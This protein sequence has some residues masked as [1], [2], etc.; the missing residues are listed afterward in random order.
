MQ[1]AKQG[2]RAVRQTITWTVLAFVVGG[3]IDTEWQSLIRLRFFGYDYAIF[4]YAFHHI[5]Q[6]AG[7]VNLYNGMLQQVYLH[8]LNYP[9]IVY[10]Q[11]V[12]PPQFALVWSVL[13]LLPF[14]V[15]LVLWLTVEV[16]CYGTSVVLLARM[17]WPNIR[18]QPAIGLGLTTAILT[19]FILDTGVANV[20]CVLL[21]AVVATFAT[22]HRRPKSWAAGIPLGFAIAFKVTPLAIVVYLLLR[23]QWRT[24][25]S[26]VMTAL[27]LSV[28]TALVVG[29]GPLVYYL[30]H[31]V[32]F[33]QTSM[34]NGPAP[35]NQSL[36]GVLQLYGLHHALPA[37]PATQRLIFLG[38][39]LMV[40]LIIGWTTLR[41]KPNLLMDMGLAS[42]TPLLF[43]PLVEQMHM[44]LALPAV[45]VLMKT[46]A[47][48]RPLHHGN[49]GTAYSSPAAVTLW[50]I[51][52]LSVACLSLPVTYALN[53]LVRYAPD[54]YWLHA[55]M[56]TVLLVAFA[57][58]VFVL[59][60]RSRRDHVG[61][62]EPQSIA[63]DRP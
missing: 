60:R 17:L 45:L 61:R 2:V 35:Y 30:T 18:L 50:A 44:V 39:A 23:K 62:T 42:L 1:H 14:Y 7:V 34:R 47:D 38:Y 43:S 9:I 53:E 28:M 56:F 41:T 36:L 51:V 21:L 11:Y 31:F 57:G 10:D 6:S 3:L 26:A 37:S 20:N 52:L 12:Y 48:E 49:R 33:G 58:C 4:Y 24:A 29:V 25:S 59:F 40:A 5:L 15:S 19:P 55:P 16:V 63:V 54:T 27:L 13:G 46:A 32:Q 8:T 22:L